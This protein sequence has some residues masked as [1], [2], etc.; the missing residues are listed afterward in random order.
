MWRR[1]RIYC[2]KG[3][4]SHL[5]ER[6]DFQRAL[7]DYDE[8]FVSPCTLNETNCGGVLGRWTPKIRTIAT[9]PCE[10]A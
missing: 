5:F 2:P 8:A 10:D 9:E 6:P 4:V 3:D 1:W 7:F